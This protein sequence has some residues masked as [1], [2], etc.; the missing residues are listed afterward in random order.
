MRSRL[1]INSAAVLTLAAALAF[2]TGASAQPKKGTWSGTYAAFGTSRAT[3]IGKSRVL[4]VFD[5]NGLYTTNGMFDHTTWHCWGSGDNTNG[6]AEARGSCVGTDPA[7]DQVVLDWA[8]QKH[9]ASQKI[10]KGSLVLT[11]GTGKYAG[12]TGRGTYADDGRMFRPTEKGT[13]FGH[14]TSHGSYTLP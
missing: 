14:N 11:G 12:I 6:M 2:A 3:Q 8:E 10:V 4:L 9:P 1:Y 13:F 7:G 5:E